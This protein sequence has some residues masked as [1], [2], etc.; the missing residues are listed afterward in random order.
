M[1][2]YIVRHGEVLHN[3]LKQYNNQDEDLT[4]LGIKQAEEARKLL[5]NISYD[6]IISSPLV[7]AKHT[8]EIIN[9]KNK[10]RRSKRRNRRIPI[11]P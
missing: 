8:A 10:S 1:K 5:K 2:V 6:L 9:I 4:K 7:R 11:L 3:R